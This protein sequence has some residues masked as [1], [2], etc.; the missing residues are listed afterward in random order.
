[1]FGS[2]IRRTSWTNCANADDIGSTVVLPVR[3]TK[4]L[5]IL[6]SDG[7]SVFLTWVR[8]LTLFFVMAAE[9]F[10]LQISQKLQNFAVQ[11]KE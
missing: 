5:G 9:D 1:V 4:D 11:Q 10:R 6:G 2:I 8:F 7:F 3:I